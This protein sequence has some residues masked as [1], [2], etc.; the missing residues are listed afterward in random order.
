MRSPEKLGFFT[1][2]AAEWDAN[3]DAVVLA[4]GLATGLDALGVGPEETVLD[5]GCGTGNLTAALLDRLG[6]SGAVL[7]LD[8]AFAMLE[9]ARVKNRDPRVS[10]QLADAECLPLRSGSVDR[11]ICFSVWPHLDEPETAALELTRVLREGGR[12]HVWHLASRERINAIHAAASPAVR[13]DLLAS[14]V[15]VADLLRAAGLSPIEVIDD[16]SRFLVTAVKRTS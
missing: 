12:L 9:I 6:S 15:E 13:H 4:S 10:W 2:L 8:L 16:D 11:V 1:E 7:A 3:Q 14:G 5:V